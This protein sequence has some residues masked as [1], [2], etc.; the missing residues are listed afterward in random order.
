MSNAIARAPPGPI[1]ER[2]K[3]QD[4]QI[5]ELKSSIQAMS[6]RIDQQESQNEQFKCEVR[7]DLT[8]VKHEV[9]NQ[10]RSFEETL[11]RSLRRQDQNLTEAFSELK[12]LFLEK[13]LPNKKAKATPPAGQE[14][15]DE[16][17]DI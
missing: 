10:C 6:S 1:E 13:P 3:I 4:Q 15:E 12:A 16:M 11:H 7:K 2:F 9:A 8:E 5:S 17:G 14:D